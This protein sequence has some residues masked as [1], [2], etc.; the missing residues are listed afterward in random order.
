MVFDVLFKIPH[1]FEVVVIRIIANDYI[2][3]GNDILQKTKP[4]DAGE[5]EF[6]IGVWACHRSILRLS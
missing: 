4:V 1:I 6:D 3:I 5:G 2:G